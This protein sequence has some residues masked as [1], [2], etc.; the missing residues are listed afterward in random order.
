MPGGCVGSVDM[1]RNYNQKHRQQ[2]KQQREQSCFSRFHKITENYGYKNVTV[3]TN[4][5]A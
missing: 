5:I 1:C 4:L 3:K 2:A